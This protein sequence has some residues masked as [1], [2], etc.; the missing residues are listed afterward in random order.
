MPEKQLKI[1][2]VGAGPVGLITALNLAKVG[3]SVT[4]LEA[5]PD[6]ENSPR[7]MGYGPPGVDELERA[8]V[9]ADARAAGMDESFYEAELR[10][11]SIDGKVVTSLNTGM[12]KE[13]P[14]PVMCGQ[15][16]LA[17]IIKRHLQPYKNAEIKWNHTV[18]AID[19][20]EN[21]VTVT[22]ETPDGQVKITGTHLVG[23]DGARSTVRKLLGLTYDGFTYD[24]QVVATNVVYPFQDYGYSLGQFVIHPDHFA[25]IGKIDP[26]GTYRVSYAEDGNLSYEQVVLAR[27]TDSGARESRLQVQSTVPR[28]QTCQI[29]SQDVFTIQ[30][31][32]TLCILL[33]GRKSS[34]RGRR[35]ACL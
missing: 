4:L 27:K 22:C 16:E 10:W 1:V 24:K 15:N 21:D 25:L 14:P 31:S 11:I 30:T 12:V 9:A 34:S 13:G 32:S 35:G 2:I 20:T 17:K 19:Q 29:R 18:T 5:L 28:T 3:I 6:V 26:S 23:A 8:G 33:Q 7:A